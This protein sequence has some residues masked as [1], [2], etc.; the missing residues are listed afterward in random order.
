MTIEVSDVNALEGDHD[1]PTSSSFSQTQEH[2]DGAIP[3]INMPSDYDD[4]LYGLDD[5]DF[6]DFDGVDD[7]VGE[8]KKACRS[9][10]VQQEALETYAIE[11][12]DRDSA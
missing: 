6:N 8:A 4:L 11:Q 9:A 12:E 2:M 5:N 3:D 7:M 1:C 10:E